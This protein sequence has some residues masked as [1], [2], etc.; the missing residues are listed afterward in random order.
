MTGISLVA[1]FFVGRLEWEH[2]LLALRLLPG[3]FLGLFSTRWI[4]PVLDRWWL[5]P[6]VLLLA[7]VSELA[8]MLR[9]FAG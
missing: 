1:L 5:P 8:A 7:A 2:V 3:L 9:G 4:A 6:A